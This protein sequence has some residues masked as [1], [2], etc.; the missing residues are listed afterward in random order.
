MKTALKFQT[1]LINRSRFYKRLKIIYIA[2]SKLKI[3]ACEKPSYK[4]YVKY[5]QKCILKMKQ[6]MRKVFIAHCPIY[7]SLQ[8]LHARFL[9]YSLAFTSKETEFVV[10]IETFKIMFF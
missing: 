6:N 8:I 2:T 1:N 5:L 7:I 3:K 10:N 9:L 4:G